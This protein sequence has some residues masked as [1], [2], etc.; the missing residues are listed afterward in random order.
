LI[1]TRAFDQIDFARFRAKAG[2]C[3]QYDFSIAA[4]IAATNSVRVSNE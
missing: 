2:A 4:L 3:G 1:K